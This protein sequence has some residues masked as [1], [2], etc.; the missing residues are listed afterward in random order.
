MAFTLHLVRDDT[1]VNKTKVKFIFLDDGGMRLGL[2][3]PVHSTAVTAFHLLLRLLH[4][5]KTQK[6][7]S[8]EL[9]QDD[10]R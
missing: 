8:H 2:Y 4:A 7:Q 10:S 6:Q 5:A 3:A 1:A 9:T